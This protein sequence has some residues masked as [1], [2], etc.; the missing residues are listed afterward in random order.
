MRYLFFGLFLLSNFYSYSHA[1]QCYPLEVLCGIC[2]CS[3]GDKTVPWT[4][5]HGLFV[6]ASCYEI[7]KNCEAEKNKTNTYFFGLPRDR[8]H[9]AI[10]RRLQHH[11]GRS[12]IKEF[13]HAHG[14]EKLQN[15]FAQCSGINQSRL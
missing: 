14:K 3:Q 7:I 5:D 2:L 10:I 8:K 13:Y 12:S 4:T 1:M 11:L 15:L 6:H 9:A